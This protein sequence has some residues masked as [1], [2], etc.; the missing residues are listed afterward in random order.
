MKTLE[1]IVRIVELLLD[2]APSAA[3]VVDIVTRADEARGR[4]EKLDPNDPELV[5]AF[6]SAQKAI[7]R[8]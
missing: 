6:S 5:E 1:I 3:K 2:L 7:D 4:G 8:L